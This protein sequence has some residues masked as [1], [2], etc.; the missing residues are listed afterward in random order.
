MKKEL[1]DALRKLKKR[2]VDTF[3]VTV[4]S[5]NKT[6]GT[7]IVS[8]DEIE[9]TDVQ[10]CSI[11]DGKENK[12]FLFPV[13]GSSVLVS[14]I[15]EDLKRLYIETY[16]DIESLDLNIK[17]VQFKVSEKGFLLKKE[18]ETLKSLIAELITAVENMSFV[19]TTSAGA[20][21]TT[22]LINAS[23]FSAV[24]EKFNQFLNDV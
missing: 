19:V 16:S 13:V 22:T 3:P 15:N 18:N 7:C 10:L 24:K 4:I 11:I 8:D 12:F 14:P 23:Q 20:G 21:N 2:D 5:V 9:Y 17:A 1:Q 6:Q